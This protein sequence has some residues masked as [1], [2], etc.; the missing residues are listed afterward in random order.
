MFPAGANE[1]YYDHYVMTVD[2][3]RYIGYSYR[4]QRGKIRYQVHDS[5]P[6][7]S[8]INLLG[9]GQFGFRRHLTRELLNQ[10]QF[11]ASPEV[12]SSWQ[13][14]VSGRLKPAYNSY[15]RNIRITIDPNQGFLPVRFDVEYAHTQ[16]KSLE[17]EVSEIRPV[18]SILVPVAGTAQL[19]SIKEHYP[20]GLTIGDI[21]AMSADEYARIKDQVKQTAEPLGDAHVVS[22][23]I[24]SVNRVEP[25]QFFTL[26]VPADIRMFDFTRDDPRPKSPVH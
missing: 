20:N 22:T 9:Y 15:E 19:F 10:D 24:I 16:T 6:G 26:E 3:D 17:I 25:R 23:E 1:M 11:S 4:E 7:Y 13:L 5:F 18:G 14:V 2:G 8:V 21:N 12:V